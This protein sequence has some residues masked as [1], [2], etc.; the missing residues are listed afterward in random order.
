MKSNKSPGSDDIFDNAV[1]CIW[2]K[3]QNILQSLGYDIQII[4]PSI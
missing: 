2:P 1:F 4:F 3:I